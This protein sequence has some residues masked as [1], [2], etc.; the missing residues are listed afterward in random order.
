MGKVIIKK[1][2][3]DGYHFTVVANNGQVVGVS[4]TYKSLK[5]AKS[6]IESVKRNRNSYI[7]DQTVPDF[8]ELGF[9]KWQIFKD[10]AGDFRFRLVAM[11]GETVLAASEGYSRKESAI[12]GLD[13][14]RANLEELNI[15]GPEESRYMGIDAQ[16]PSFG[17]AWAGRGGPAAANRG[18]AVMAGEGSDIAAGWDFCTSNSIY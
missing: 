8:K 5:S 2:S 4:Q 11:N 12:K 18:E 16:R 7:E 13:S 10:A 9:P 6:G 17:K 3:N 14:V 1:T 15:V